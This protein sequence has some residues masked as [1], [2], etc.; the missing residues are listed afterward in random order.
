MGLC[1][2]PLSFGAVP[3]PLSSG[4]A[5]SS[6]SSGAVPS[7]LPSGAVHITT[8]IW[9]CDITTVIWD[10]AH[11]HCHLG[12]C[13]SP[14]SSGAVHITIVNHSFHTWACLRWKVDIFLFFNYWAWKKIENC[15]FKC[16]PRV[17]WQRCGASLVIDLNN[18]KVSLLWNKGSSTP[19]QD[20]LSNNR[21]GIW[22]WGAQ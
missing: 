18:V 17:L 16:F 6:L 22:T 9:G 4:A 1:M 8:V 3:S 20:L 13:I 12:L 11:H 7:P 21:A 2:S 14:L 10:C 5:Q 15:D 19:S